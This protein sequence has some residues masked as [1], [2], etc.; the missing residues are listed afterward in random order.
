MDQDLKNAMLVQFNANPDMVRA[1]EEEVLKGIF[2]QGVFS[3]TKFD[4]A[5]NWALSLVWN[6]EGGVVSD[7][8]L[9][10]ELRACAE[11]LRFIMSSFNGI[12]ENYKIEAPKGGKTGN[13]AR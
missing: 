9:G 13:P 11:A 8:Q 1:V 5:K 2:T 3:D 7:E 4:T 10:S 12:K 6:K